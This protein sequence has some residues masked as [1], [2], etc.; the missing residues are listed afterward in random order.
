MTASSLGCYLTKKIQKDTPPQLQ[1][2]CVLPLLS[3]MDFKTF[4]TM[5][6]NTAGSLP[7]RKALI[8]LERAAVAQ[9]RTA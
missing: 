2:I 5:I 1:E 3:L 6:P 8:H 7:K 9:D 4:L